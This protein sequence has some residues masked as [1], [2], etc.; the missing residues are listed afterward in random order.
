M[1]FV[2]L[3]A[4][5]MNIADQVCFQCLLSWQVAEACLHVD[6]VLA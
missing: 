1:H 6:A 2:K 5:L 4:A 3:L